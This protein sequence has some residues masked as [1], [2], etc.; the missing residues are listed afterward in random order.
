M[1]RQPL[2]YFNQGYRGNQC[3]SWRPHGCRT[4]VLQP[5]SSKELV[6]GLCETL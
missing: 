2:S 6:S 3:I 1:Q 4:D 5:S